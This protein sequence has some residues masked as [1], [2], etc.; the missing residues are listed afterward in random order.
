MLFWAVCSCNL[1]CF[2]IAAF[3]VINFSTGLFWYRLNLCNLAD[4]AWW[5]VVIARIITSSIVAFIGI[6]LDVTN[7]FSPSSLENYAFMQYC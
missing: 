3:I 4:I 5:W 6:N 7:I 2:E 1:F